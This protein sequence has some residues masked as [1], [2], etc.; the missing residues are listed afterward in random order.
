M[1]CIVKRGHCTAISF[2]WPTAWATTVKNFWNHAE[3]T[4]AGATRFR[5]QC[6]RCHDTYHTMWKMPFTDIY[7]SQSHLQ[8]LNYLDLSINLLIVYLVKSLQFIQQ[9]EWRSNNF[10]L[11]VETWKVLH[12]H[13]S[14]N[15]M[16][17][18][19]RWIHVKFYFSNLRSSGKVIWLL[20]SRS[21]YEVKKI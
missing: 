13:N 6:T 11:R 15:Y 5:K 14:K 7:I 18:K 1:R 8:F 17:T 16:I 9:S 4:E 12:L 2:A 21:G 20:F 19:G 10:F 3:K